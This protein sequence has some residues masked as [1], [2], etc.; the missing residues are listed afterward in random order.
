MQQKFLSLLACL[1]LFFV[2]TLS[3]AS[4]GLFSIINFIKEDEL[5]FVFGK[6]TGDRREKGEH[7]RDRKEAQE[8]ETK[9]VNE[10][11]KKKKKEQAI[12]YISESERMNMEEP[13][14]SKVQSSKCF[15]N[16]QAAA[17]RINMI[18]F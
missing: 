1:F 11:K 7:R 18:L 3:R 5:V 17:N 6:Q 2:F 14:D 15:T 9:T 13:N 12:T 16:Y 4:V 8:A 10:Q